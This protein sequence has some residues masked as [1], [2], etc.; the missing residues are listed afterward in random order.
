MRPI[1]AAYAATVI[2]AFALG[3]GYA[4]YA[5]SS[6][7]VRRA[8]DI[9]IATVHVAP[10]RG[11]RKHTV[12]ECTWSG[13]T[14]QASGYVRW[15]RTH[16][17]TV[18]E[19]ARHDTNAVCAINGNTYVDSTRTPAGPVRTHGV[20]IT[21]HYHSE[22]VYGFLGRRI[23]FGWRAVNRPGVENVM[24][25]KAWLVRHGR[26]IRDHAQAP[27]TT[28]AQFGCS[29][30]GTDGWYGCFRTAAVEFKGG[31]YGL[32]SIGL[33]SM[34]E[35]GRILVRMG[36]VEAV[37]GDSGGGAEGWFAG[38][39]FGTIPNG[40]RYSNWHRRIPDAI[41]VDAGACPR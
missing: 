7:A 11:G 14:A 34:P 37:T 24:S 5:A 18:T 21:R 31:R 22:P 12:M 32:V 30:R 25:G 6:P 4:A 19:F 23:V 20:W 9:R 40:G 36:A 26:A 1:R 2:G 3:A 13:Y 10:W 27:Y 28:P 33:A 38:H 35:A 16:L 39:P 17:K 29:A 41:I 15:Q 8:T